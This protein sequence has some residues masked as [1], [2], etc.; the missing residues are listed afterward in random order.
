MKKVF[1]TAALAAIAV[2][3]GL[4][5]RTSELTREFVSPTRVM[6][7]QG[8][9]TGAEALLEN[10]QG[11]ATFAN[12]KS[13]SLTSTADQQA[14]ILLDY[15]KEFQ[16]GLQLVTSM[17]PGGQPIK[18]RIRFGESVTEAMSDISP[19][20]GATNDHAI[21]DFEATLPWFGFREFGNSG[22]RFVRIDVLDIDKTLV[23]T[24]VNGIK[25]YRDIEYAGSFKSNDERLNQ[26]WQTGAYTVHLNMQQYIWDGIKRDRLVW[27][28]DMHPEVM[29]V[30]T[31]FGDQ[32]VVESSLDLARDSAPLPGMMNGMSAY[33]LWWM[34]IHRDWYKY[35]GDAG[36]LLAQKEYMKG[37]ADVLISKID[38]N[39]RDIITDHFLDWPS[40]ADEKASGTGFHALFIMAMEA[41]QEI[42][43]IEGEDEYVAKCADA[44]KM[45]RG[46]APK[47]AKEF[48]AE[49]KPASD[50][51]RKQ[52]VALMCLADMI[53]PEQAAPDL[54]CDGPL[55]FSTFYGYY[56]L[57]ALAKCGKHAEAL[58]IASEFWGGMLDLG[59][60][61]FWEDFDIRWLE[62][63]GR[64]DEFTPADKVDVHL[65]YGGYC[66]KQLRHSLCHGWASGPTSFMSKN[67][68]G[69]YPV[70][71][72]SKVVRLE[73]HLAGLETL[74][75][76]LPTPYGPVK[77]CM[78]ANADGTVAAKI[79][80]P[81]EVLVETAENVKVEE[82]NYR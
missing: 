11:Q 41:A 13:C 42:F 57:E 69:L 60:T 40:R 58:K 67:I 4:S 22:F 79:C 16:G 73:P 50:L 76:S 72:G 51:G 39:G 18:V 25:E 6:W 71:Y 53:T 80:A 45:L 8:N 55:G 47:V 21:R 2:C 82:I 3:Q 33:S 26:I 81:T 14:S 10:N 52:A 61:T 37:L 63:A 75:G 44:V 49:K 68:L 78:K 9:V 27:I 36:Y 15:G 32:K 17:Y 66:Y 19:E 54:L 70:A 65:T 38:K 34:I 48:Y 62:N 30:N 43:T 28:G 56:M 24:D 5:A 1:L 77:V 12:I 31:V 7:T 74:S 29:C 46:A 23:L 20:T 59:A 35:Q 64:I